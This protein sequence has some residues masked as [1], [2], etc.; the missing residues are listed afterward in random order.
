MMIQWNVIWIDGEEEA[1]IQALYMQEAAA[2][3]C[4][5]KGIL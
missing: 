2:R 4:Q 3:L 1:G 5:S